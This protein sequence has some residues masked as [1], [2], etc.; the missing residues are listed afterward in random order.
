MR[1]SPNHSRREALLRQ[2]ASKQKDTNLPAKY[3]SAKSAALIRKGA[4]K[5]GTRRRRLVRL[6]G[7]AN[8]G[9]RRTTHLFPQG[10]VRSRVS[11]G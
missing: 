6:P 7:G 3:A 5:P 11:D 9:V 4:G 10:G 1:Q 8:R 2:G